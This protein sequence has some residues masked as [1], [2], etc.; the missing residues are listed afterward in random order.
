MNKNWTKQLTTGRLLF[1]SLCSLLLLSGSTRVSAEKP[2][3]DKGDHIVTGGDLAFMNTAAPGGMAEV[4][5]GRLAVKQAS[6]EAVKDFGQKMIT[7]HSQAGEKLKA[8]A[9][10]K[11]ITLPSKLMPAQNET[12]AKL[13]KLKG[14][15]FDR[16][17]VAAM[18]NAHKKDVAAFKA[19]AN[20]AT[21]AD[22]KAFAGSTLPVLETHLEMIQSLAAK[23]GVKAEKGQ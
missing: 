21:D 17:Y 23:T 19:V 22:V 18:V 16:A 9:Q 2:P 4:A 10:E 8:L 7:D 12:M 20:N 3:S 13:S 15:D 5:L 14:A 1:L 11:R 6:S